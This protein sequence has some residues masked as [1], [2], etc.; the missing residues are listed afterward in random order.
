MLET[1]KIKFN[2][3]A[4]YSLGFFFFFFLIFPHQHTILLSVTCCKL[5]YVIC[6][7][8][9]LWDIIIEKKIKRGKTDK[10]C[11]FSEEKLTPPP[12]KKKGYQKESYRVHEKQCLSQWKMMKYVC[13]TNMWSN[14]HAYLWYQT[15]L[16][17][18]IFVAKAL[19]NRPQPYPLVCFWTRK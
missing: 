18:G 19:A 13:L 8:L 11:Y 16:P 1:T 10:I 3:N 14:I 5:L 15:E 9:F 2:F 12:K 17:V 4:F 6:L 7:I